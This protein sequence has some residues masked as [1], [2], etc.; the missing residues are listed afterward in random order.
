MR[1][2][3]M[4]VMV[5]MVAVGCEEVGGIEGPEGPTGP[6]G[7]AGPTGPT[8]PTGPM[9]TGGGA[10]V[11]SSPW[12]APDYGTWTEVPLLDARA[13]VYD[14]AAPEVTQQV[15]DGGTVLVYAKLN[16]YTADV[17]A[18]DD[19]GM[20]PVTLTYDFYGLQIDTWSARLTPGNIELRFVNSLDIYDTVAGGHEFRY[21]VVPPSP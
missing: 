2:W 5:A 10:A 4:M 16:G 1:P 6:E 8:G 15:L 12:I 20:L 13:F 17:W 18:L 7:P 14:I 3:M 21:V 11:V 19:V 9:G